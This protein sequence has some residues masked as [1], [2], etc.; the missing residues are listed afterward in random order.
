VK[1][2]SMTPITF[3]PEN[4]NPR[5]W[6]GEVFETVSQ[7]PKAPSLWRERIRYRS[8]LRRLVNVG[9][10]MIRDVGLVWEDAQLEVDKPFWQ[11]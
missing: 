3:A 5:N 8:E 1:T 2:Y 6:I 9:S 11:D 7:L 4:L 10:H